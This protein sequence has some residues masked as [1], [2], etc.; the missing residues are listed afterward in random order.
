MIRST[1]DLYL[2]RLI[3]FDQKRQRPLEKKI[4][5]MNQPMG[6]LE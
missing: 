2:E 1:L 4:Q 3:M 5:K 6:H